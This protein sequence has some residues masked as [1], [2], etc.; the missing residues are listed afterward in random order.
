MIINERI[1][2]YI[3]KTLKIEIWSL[4]RHKETQ[5]V[6]IENI[7]YIY[8]VEAEILEKLINLNYYKENPHFMPLDHKFGKEFKL[9]KT[10]EDIENADDYEILDIDSQSVYIDDELIFTDK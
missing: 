7:Y 4:A 6:S 10:N 1:T 5:K 9:I 3:M 2:K 8:K